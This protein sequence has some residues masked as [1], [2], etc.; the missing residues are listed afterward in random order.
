MN[1]NEA[2]VIATRELTK[3][4]GKKVALDGLSIELRSGRIYGLVGNNGSGK[5]TLLRILSG[6]SP[7]YEGKVEILGREDRKGL[8]LSRRS[9]GAFI[10]PPA[11]YDT[12]SIKSNL[13]MRGILIGKNDKEQIKQL[14]EQLKLKNRDIGGRTIR[15]C[16][17]GQ[18]QLYGVASA[19]VGDPELLLLDEPF[20]GLDSKGI[21]DIRELL[22]K[23]NREN[24]VTILISSSKPAEIDNFVTDYIFI[25]N[26]RLVEQ[27]SS[28]ELDARIAE[29]GVEGVGD[30]FSSLVPSKPGKERTK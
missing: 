21:E 13:T 18:K 2:P 1:T 19:L 25:D 14:R 22:L 9:M 12:F 30:Y 5:T 29:R 16:T 8:R 23:T 20:D 11:Y 27:I 24:G 4:Y 26:G 3:R 6:L 28:D 7:R 15:S 17:P 10:C